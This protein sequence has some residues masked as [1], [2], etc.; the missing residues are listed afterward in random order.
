MSFKAGKTVYKE[1]PK[2][3]VDPFEGL[4]SFSKE[5]F[6]YLF[7]KIQDMNFKGSEMQKIYELTTKLQNLY[8]YLL[9][10][11]QITIDI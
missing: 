10:K 1:L 4:P 6:K 2:E 11:D 9:S 7:Q 3:I 8:L 5:D